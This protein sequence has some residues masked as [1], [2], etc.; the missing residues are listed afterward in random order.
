MAG[1]VSTLPPPKVSTA[2]VQLLASS[3]S[4]KLPPPATMSR[5]SW[6]RMC[7]LHLT[8]CLCGGMQLSA[9]LTSF[10]LEFSALGQSRLPPV[11][12]ATL[13]VLIV[14][15]PMRPLAR[16]TLPTTLPCVASTEWA[17]LQVLSCKLALHIMQNTWCTF[18]APHDHLIP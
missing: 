6:K 4:V 11:S 15:P 9:I 2:F 1:G 8:L 13:L 3:V 17:E 7:T 14:G 16:D 18:H 10:S 12:C 5:A